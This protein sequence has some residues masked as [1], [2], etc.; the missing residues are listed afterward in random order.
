M[1]DGSV[2]AGLQLKNRPE[3]T[4]IDVSGVQRKS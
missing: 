2:K 4:V 1:T 3:I